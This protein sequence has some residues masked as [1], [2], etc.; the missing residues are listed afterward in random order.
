VLD[1]QLSDKV[2]RE[3]ISALGRLK[4]LQQFLFFNHGHQQAEDRNVH[5]IGLC[6]E[7]LP[8]LHAV[9][10]KPLTLDK[11][12]SEKM[13]QALTNVCS[14]CTLQLRH[15]DVLNLDVIQSSRRCVHLP[16]LEVLRVHTTFLSMQPLALG[17]LPKLSELFIHRTLAT[18]LLNILR[19]YGRQLKTISCAFVRGW[20]TQQILKRILELCPNLSHLDINYSCAS[21]SCILFSELRPDTLSQLQTLNLNARSVENGMLVQ[22]LRLAP[23]LQSVQL[24]YSMSDHELRELAELAKEGSSMQHLQQITVCSNPLRAVNMILLEEAIV[25]CCIHCR[26][27]KHVSFKSRY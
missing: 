6:F 8:H 20:A 10:I 26:R 15:L 4:S 12:M 1:V 23:L 3:G 24:M 27:L 18:D 7:L 22:V 25:S 9:A 19:R 21:G 5:H 11:S 13:G 14:P 16:E 17:R 2:S